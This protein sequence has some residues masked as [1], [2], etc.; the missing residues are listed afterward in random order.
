MPAPL[1]TRSGQSSRN[2]QMR[3]DLGWS[4]DRR[5]KTKGAAR[6]TIKR[7]K[8]NKNLPTQTVAAPLLILDSS[9]VFLKNRGN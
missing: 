5:D 8:Q 4:K 3:A 1:T 9:V 2:A 6:N 7:T